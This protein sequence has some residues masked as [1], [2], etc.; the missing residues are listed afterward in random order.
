MNVQTILEGL[1]ARRDE[2]STERDG[3][4][5]AVEAEDRPE[6]SR[7]ILTDEEATRTNE[8]T[9]ELSEV[10]TRIGEF[11]DAD[12]A[13][14]R[15]ERALE[16]FDG[17]NPRVRIGREPMTYER[18]N[19]RRS[20]FADLWNADR[21]DRA[22]RERLGRHREEMDTVLAE[23]AV[24]LV[25]G[26]DVPKGTEFIEGDPS[27]RDLAGADTS[28]GEFV[29]PLWMVDQYAELARAGRP[30]AN[31]VQNRPLPP[32]TDSIKLPAI[33]TGT[34][35]APQTG[36]TQ[37]VE[38][39]DIVTATRSADVQTLAGQI[40]VPLQLIEQSPVAFDEVVFADLVADHAVTTDEQVING[41]GTT[42][43]LKGILQIGSI[44]T[45]A[46]TDTT[47]TYPELHPKIADSLNQVA[48]L[49]KLPPEYLVLHTRRYYWIA[50]QLDGNNRPFLPFL[51]GGPQNAPGV[52][53]GVVSEGPAANILGTPVVADP[54]SPT[55]LGASTNEDVIIAFRAS[56][57]WLFEGAVRTRA[58]A[59][60]LSG[61]LQVRLQLY[62]YAAFL[63]DRYTT[64][65]SI[66]SGTG[67]VTPTF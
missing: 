18:R 26:R 66:V 14:Q 7:G 61:T 58:L 55:T 31:L 15:A 3:I 30:T 60:V 64:A 45:T 53:Q 44:D 40:D 5:A 65:A 67:L 10:E 33:T 35:V 21:G 2:L 32:G 29:P 39:Q 56:D 4:F 59:E 46:Y 62:N 16:R 27:T 43:Q 42:G 9:R 12:A 49:R 23:R 1:R 17:R 50:A 57:M 28:G 22:A 11:V 8:L 24:D 34:S 20:Y 37:A 6:E 54:N 63:P 52:A 38:E 13:S 36:L 25:E 19:V 41:S 48:T 47:P 51:V